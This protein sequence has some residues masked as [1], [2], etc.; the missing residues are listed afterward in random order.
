M[1]IPKEHY[2]SY[3]FELPEEVMTE[4]VKAAKQV[5][6]RLDAT[7][8]DVGRT[9]LLFEGFG[10]NHV[11]AKLF[12]M[13]GT[14]NDEWKQHVS[15]VDVYFER[16]QGYISSHDYKRGDDEALAALAK[17]IRAEE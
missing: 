11:H 5:A 8:E 9:G 7:F 4:L 17:R 10:V 16:Y 3:V 15:K 14:K 12:P 1:V 2:S 13:H 6:L